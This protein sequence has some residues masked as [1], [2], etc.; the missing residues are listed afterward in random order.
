M[1]VIDIN[2]TTAETTAET[3]RK[4]KLKKCTYE[5]IGWIGS[6]TVLTAYLAPIDDTSKIILNSIGS[7]GLVII[8]LSKKTYQPV[9][10][11]SIW[12]VGGLVNYFLR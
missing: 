7:A 3:T 11:N 12:F 5:V 10:T 1:Q 9:I 2:N 6:A 4:N 8:C